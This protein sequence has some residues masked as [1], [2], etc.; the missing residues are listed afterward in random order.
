MNLAARIC[1]HAQ[2]GQILVSAAVKELAVG[3]PLHFDDVGLI[4]LKGFD[5]PV[6]LYQVGI[7]ARPSS[8]EPPQ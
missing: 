5:D 1:A 6:R 7:D 4:A 2:P 3:K 8:S